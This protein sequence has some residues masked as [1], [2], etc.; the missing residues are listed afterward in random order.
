MDI[1][2]LRADG[3]EGTSYSLVL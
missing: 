2:S 1:Q 3:W